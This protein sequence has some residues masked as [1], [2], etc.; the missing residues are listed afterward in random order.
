VKRN[1]LRSTSFIRGARR[2]V[3]QHPHIV[4]SLRAALDL[5]AEDAFHP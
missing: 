3:K 2:L 1:L 5:L 4:P